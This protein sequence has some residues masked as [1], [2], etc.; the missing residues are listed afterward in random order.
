MRGRASISQLLSTKEP[1]LGEQQSDKDTHL[2]GTRKARPEQE[3]DQQLKQELC[4]NSSLKRPRLL[5]SVGVN[6][7]LFTMCSGLTKLPRTFSC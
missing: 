6:T 2:Q 1:Y 3:T 7:G 4:L 5:V